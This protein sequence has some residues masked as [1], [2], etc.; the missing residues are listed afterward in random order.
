M[1][2]TKRG[3]SVSQ[4]RSVPRKPRALVVDD[5]EGI[6]SYLVNLLELK[7]FEVD[8]ASDGAKAATLVESGAA[9]DVVLLDVMMPGLDGIQ[10]LRRIRAFDADVPVVMLSVVGSAATIVDAMHAGATDYLNK[11]FEDDELEATLLK[12][13]ERHSLRTKK[14]ARSEIVADDSDS[15]VWKSV[16]M[17]RI[18]DVI[19]QISDTDVTVLIQGESGVG[20]EIVARAIAARSTRSDEP[21]VKVNCAAL[22]ENLLESELFGYEQGAFTGAFARKQGKFE[23][24]DKG[25]I[26]LD[27]IGEMSPGLQAKLLHVLQERT[28]TRL[29]GNVELSVDV[30]VV[31][32]THRPLLEMV[33]T[34]EFRE[35]LYFR[36]YVVNIEIP[37][38]RE[39]RDEIP[40]LVD[41]FLRRYG[42]AYDKPRVQLSKRLRELLDRYAFPGNV[43]EL[44]NMIKR[45]VV[46]ESEDSVVTEL[47]QRERGNRKSRSA[48]IELLAEVEATA[49][50]VPLRDV[51][52][53]VATQAERETIGAALE[54]T[55]WNRKQAAK[56]LGVSYKTLLQ[57]IRDIGIEADAA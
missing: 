57:K 49:G 20:K 44:E 21:F 1:A 22:P 12:V 50:E 15:A 53:L 7:G 37:P 18:R 51:A 10:T 33:E 19:D 46:L 39:R 3:K 17:Q 36:L 43:R 30:R 9:P 35:D 34:K 31:C 41:T 27:E 48:L 14:Q 28:Y 13:I 16:A 11:P 29:G 23:Q 25:T 32:A 54:R 47:E 55:C 45:M 4:G 52:R 8:S 42:A 5:A 2:V 40:A 24:A 38:L 26:F 56:V 6:R